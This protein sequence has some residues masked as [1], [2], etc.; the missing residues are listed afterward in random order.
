MSWDAYVSDKLINCDTKFGHKLVGVCAQAFVGDKTNGAKWAASPAT[1]TMADIKTTGENAGK[2][3]NQSKNLQDVLAKG[4]PDPNIGIW[5]NGEKYQMSKAD[6]DGQEVVCK[7]EKGGAVV[8]FTGKCIIVGIYDT[9]KKFKYDGKDKT[10]NIGDC[11]MVVEELRDTLN[12][13]GY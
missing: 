8:C 2:Q 3:V 6:K 1:F 7:K 13:A 4:A 9:N 12:E 5:I 11:T 10:Q